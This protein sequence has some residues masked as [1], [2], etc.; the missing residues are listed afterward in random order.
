MAVLHHLPATAAARGL[1]DIQTEGQARLL[2]AVLF[3]P[4]AG[5]LY[6]AV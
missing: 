3:P 1:P 2:L 5:C 6:A 4:V